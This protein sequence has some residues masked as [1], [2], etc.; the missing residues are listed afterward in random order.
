METSRVRNSNKSFQLVGVEKEDFEKEKSPSSPIKP[1]KTD[2]LNFNG[3]YL[4]GKTNDQE[5]SKCKAIYSQ[6]KRR[7]IYIGGMSGETLTLFNSKQ[8]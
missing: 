1:L 5:I 7:S 3:N 2:Y 8:Q 6:T 4:R